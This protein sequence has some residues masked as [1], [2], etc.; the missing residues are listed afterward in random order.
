MLRKPETA[1]SRPAEAW[2]IATMFAILKNKYL[3]CMLSLTYFTFFLVFT[4]ISL[5]AS[6]DGSSRN[7][8]SHLKR[9][10]LHL[11]NQPVMLYTS[12]EYSIKSLF[13]KLYKCNQIKEQVL[14]PH[15]GSDCGSPTERQILIVSRQNTPGREGKGEGFPREGGLES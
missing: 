2:K 12:I 6:R 13:I 15:V 5:K 9:H 8:F 14:I 11:W 7:Y 1:L 10:Q 4:S 3:K